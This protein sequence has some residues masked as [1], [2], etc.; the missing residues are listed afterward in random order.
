MKIKYLLSALLISTLMSCGSK[1]TQNNETTEPKTET[2]EPESEMTNEEYEA[3]D[4]ADCDDEVD[5]ATLFSSKIE[6]IYGSDYG[7]SEMYVDDLDE[8]GIDEYIAYVNHYVDGECKTVEDNYLAV[9]YIDGKL[10]VLFPQ[11]DDLDINNFELGKG[12]I[13]YS[14]IN[15][16]NEMVDMFLILENSKIVN[17]VYHRYSESD[18]FL[19]GLNQEACNEEDVEQYLNMETT[20]FIELPEDKFEYPWG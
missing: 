18:Y 19:K 3:S 2:T 4:C 20:P 17:K 1:S 5:I 7:S 6:E 13:K 9:N 15:K 8:D 14:G 11:D 12:V 10:N 16:E